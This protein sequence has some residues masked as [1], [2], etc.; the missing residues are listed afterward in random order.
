MGDRRP[1]RAPGATGDDANVTLS[2]PSPP[3]PALAA[4]IAGC[5][6]DQDIALVYLPYENGAG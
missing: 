2:L 6:S 4:S 1:E 5:A 3:N